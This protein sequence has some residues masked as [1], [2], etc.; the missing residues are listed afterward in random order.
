MIIGETEHFIINGMKYRAN[1][2]WKFKENNAQRKL[3]R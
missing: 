2:G 3:W 1:N